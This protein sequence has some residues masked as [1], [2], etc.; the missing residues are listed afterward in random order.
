MQTEIAVALITACIPA[1]V[2]LVSH[3]IQAR[4]L[5]RNSAKQS[6]LQ[7]ILEDKIAVQEGHLPENYQNIL[8][9]YDEYHR[10]GG[11]SYVTDKVEAYKFWYS[12]L[13]NNLKKK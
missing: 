3:C 10:N 11:N 9:E 2:T 6:I 7:M 4:G 13:D 12:R 8:R 1:T 5:R